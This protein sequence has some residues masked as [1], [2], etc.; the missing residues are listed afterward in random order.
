MSETP[1]EAAKTTTTDKMII[2]RGRV[3]LGGMCLSYCW[4]GGL[5]F[6]GW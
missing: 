3:R 6:V 2:R 5:W 4:P 1:R